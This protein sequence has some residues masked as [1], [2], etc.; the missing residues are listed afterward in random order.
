[1]A[2]LRRVGLAR[3]VRCSGLPEHEVSSLY[4]E[5]ISLCRVMPERP[6]RIP[7]ELWEYLIH[8]MRVISAL[9]STAEKD[10]VERARTRAV[11]RFLPVARSRVQQAYRQQRRQGTVEL[12]LAWLANHDES[13]DEGRELCREALRLEREARLQSCRL[14]GTSQLATHQAAIVQRALAYVDE[15]MTD[16]PDGFAA[17]DLVIRLLD[18]LRSVL[19][20]HAGPAERPDPEVD[21]IV[22]GLGNLL[23]SDELGLGRQAQ[24]TP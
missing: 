22:L 16:E 9:I 4:F 17:V 15:A 12:R 8:C 10:A 1:M 14:L 18:L 20:S 6:E 24:D 23:F 13:A 11:S 5:L 7:P 2:D 19:E 21:R 3:V